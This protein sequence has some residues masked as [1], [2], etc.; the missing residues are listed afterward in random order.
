MDHIIKK[1]AQQSLGYKLGH[2]LIKVK[3]LDRA[4][5]SFEKNG[6]VV[7]YGSKKETA[8]NAM[9]YFENGS[10]IELFTTEGPKA[11]EIL[12]PALLKFFSFRDESFANRMKRYVM[13]PYGL[14]DFALDVEPSNQF[15]E[16]VAN[17]NTE[18]IIFSTRKMK[19][20]DNKGI[21][22]RWKIAYCNDQELPFLMSA[23]SPELPHSPEIWAHKNGAVSIKSLFIETND[24]RKTAKK[25]KELLGKPSPWH[26][27]NGELVLEP[28]NERG[29]SRL[30]LN[31]KDGGEITLEK[32]HLQSY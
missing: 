23:Y 10:F 25:Y 28:G 8:R 1:E 11:L 3:N 18:R 22:L 12:Y 26:F 15:E 6:F 20:V 7:C 21:P 13:G 4:V 29:V 24:L 5:T 31:R 2:V 32:Q 30:V 27:S 16:A 9:I 14:S 19:R 17:L